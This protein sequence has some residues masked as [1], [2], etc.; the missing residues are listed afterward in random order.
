MTI[1]PRKK[2]RRLQAWKREGTRMLAELWR[3]AKA[4]KKWAVALLAV[5][6]AALL[7]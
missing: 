4:R 6:I 1:A 5:V 3:Y 7:K 2:R